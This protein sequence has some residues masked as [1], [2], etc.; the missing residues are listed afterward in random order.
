MTVAFPARTPER[1]RLL[2]PSVPALNAYGG[3]IGVLVED[4]PAIG[5]LAGLILGVEHVTALPTNTG[6]DAFIL[7]TQNALE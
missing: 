3:T 7:S 2:D 5:E 6:V 4:F 1:L